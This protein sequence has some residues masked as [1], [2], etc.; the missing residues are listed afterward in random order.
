MVPLALRRRHGRELAG[1]F[2]RDAAAILEAIHQIKPACH[3]D[4]L[5]AGFGVIV[6]Q[7]SAQCRIGQ[8]AAY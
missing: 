4:K 1:G 5:A 8:V 7:Q 6:C 2:E 3:Q